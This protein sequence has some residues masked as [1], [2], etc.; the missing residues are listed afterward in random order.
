M[1]SGDSGDK[2]CIWGY[3]TSPRKINIDCLLRKKNVML[4][5]CHFGKGGF[6]LVIGGCLSTV[7]RLF[8]GLED[9]C[10]LGIVCIRHHGSRSRATS[11]GSMSLQDQGAWMQ[12]IIIWALL[13]TE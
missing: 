4:A 12:M 8:F 1:H 3:C 9:F 6:S 5:I 13:D 10:F 11:K 7:A 2:R